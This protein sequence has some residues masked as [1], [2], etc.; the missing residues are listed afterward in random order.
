MTT[1]QVSALVERVPA[2]SAQLFGRLAQF[3]ITSVRCAGHSL[4]T[5]SRSL[6]GSNLGVSLKRVCP[7]S[8]RL[9]RP[10]DIFPSDRPLDLGCFRVRESAFLPR[11]EFAQLLSLPVEKQQGEMSSWGLEIPKTAGPVLV[12]IDQCF[13]NG[14]KGTSHNFST[15]T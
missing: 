4:R 10:E 9:S 7:H 5:V 3:A 11:E 13:E 1:S 6:H 14:G 8:H 12:M 2:T 15:L